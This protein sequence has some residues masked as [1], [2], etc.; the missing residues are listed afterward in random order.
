MT[1]VQ[2]LATDPLW[3]LKLCAAIVTAYLVHEYLTDK[4]DGGGDPDGWA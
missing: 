3:P 2:F 1:W 4:I